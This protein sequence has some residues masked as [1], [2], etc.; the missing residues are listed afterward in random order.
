[1]DYA[2]VGEGIFGAVLGGSITGV[3]SWVKFSNAIAIIRNDVTHLT[4]RCNECRKLFR[5]EIMEQRQ[6]ELNRNS[7]GKRLRVQ[8]V[9]IEERHAKEGTDALEVR[10]TQISNRLAS[11]EEYLRGNGSGRRK[12]EP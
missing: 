4:D 10:L 8:E 12:H 11:I 6:S 3:V 1:M 2:S 5:D 7:E 9:E